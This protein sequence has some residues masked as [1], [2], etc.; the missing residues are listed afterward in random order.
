MEYVG[1]ESIKKSYRDILQS[2]GNYGEA[3]A[4]ETKDFSDPVFSGLQI[5]PEEEPNISTINDAFQKIGID[6]I[7]LDSQFASV[8]EMYN[9]LMND[10]LMSLDSVDEIIKGEQERIQDMNIVLGRLDE[11]SS[12]RTLKYSD[13]SGDASSF[14]ENTFTVAATTRNSVVLTVEDISG[15][16]YEGNKYVYNNGHFEQSSFDTSNRDFMIDESS[17]SYY[18]YCRIT[19]KNKQQHYPQ[20]VNFDNVEAECVVTFHSAVPFN[21]VRIQSDIDSVEITQI[22]VSNDDGV[23]YNNTLNKSIKINNSES[24][25]D[26]EGYIYGAGVLC[27]PRTNY[28]KVHLKSNGTFND[29]LAFQKLVLEDDTIANTNVAFDKEKFVKE[30]LEPVIRYQKQ[31]DSLMAD[32]PISIIIAIALAITEATPKKIGM[33]N[34]WGLEYNSDLTG[35]REDKG[36]CAFIDR[37]EGLKAISTLIREDER[38]SVAMNGI[39]IFSLSTEKDRAMRELCYLLVTAEKAEITYLHANRYM[40]KYNLL[41]YDNETV[42]DTLDDMQVSKF[43]Q[44]FRRYD[45]MRS[46]Y[47]DALEDA[48]TIIKLDSA[49][50]HVIRVNNIIG[51]TNEYSSSSYMNTVELLTG[52]VQSVA[53]FANEYIPPTFPSDASTEGYEPYIRYFL[54]I[55]GKDY[56]VV[57]VNSHKQGIKVIRYSNYSIVEDYTLHLTEPIKSAKLTIKLITPDSSYSPYVSNIKVCIGKAV[58]K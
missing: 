37:I 39:N 25:Y 1:I 9:D 38:F 33:F 14:D 13:F 42:R 51:F 36:Y 21:T 49:V 18:E 31:I 53:I 43:E 3:A 55:N 16:G 50:R 27:F 54:N 7:A 44:Y 40:E 26:D 15:N 52:P 22:S 17:T 47:E 19:M 12:V 5:H 32:I 35:Q 41:S 58:T 48:E 4:L 8:A 45:T 34:F 56:E 29:T 6:F 57:P 28:L 2:R 23:T 24:K 20:D 30:Y 10:V 46:S 11:F